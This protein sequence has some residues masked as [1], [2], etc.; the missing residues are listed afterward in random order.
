MT[1]TYFNKAT[2][3]VG[4]LLLQGKPKL[5]FLESIEIITQ[6]FRTDEISA[7]LNESGFFES[8]IDDSVIKQDLLELMPI[9]FDKLPSE[10]LKKTVLQALVFKNF[11][12]N[13]PDFTVYTYNAYRA[14]EGHYRYILS[15]SGITYSGTSIRIWQDSI[16]EENYP[17]KLRDNC[18]AAVNL[19]YGNRSNEFIEYLTDVNR[20]INYERN[21]Y[22]HWEKFD[23]DISLDETALIEDESYAR[24][25]IVKCLTQIEK[26]YKIFY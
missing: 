15:E 22:F 4:K 9:S 17:R 8:Q 11:K 3:G 2:T 16:S 20:I 24:N 7:T 5:L 14:L 25:V 10:Q 6:L 18:E 23:S 19:K 26:Y 21:K 12:S 13:W 1:I